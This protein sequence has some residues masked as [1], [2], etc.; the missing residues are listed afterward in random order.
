[1]L[2]G[3][4][5]LPTWMLLPAET[6]AKKNRRMCSSCAFL[7]EKMKRSVAQQLQGATGSCVCLLWE[8]LAA[9][10]GAEGLSPSP[11]F[12]LGASSV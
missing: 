4:S 3:G 7:K 12:Q 1:M 10:A 2:S 11:K 5:G 8:P 9:K 6:E